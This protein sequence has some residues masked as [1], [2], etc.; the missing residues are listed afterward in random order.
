MGNY[1]SE[2]RKC[3][4]FYMECDICKKKYCTDCYINKLRNLK[5][6]WGCHYCGSS[7]GVHS[8]ERS[9]ISLIG[10]VKY[11]RKW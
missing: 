1:C 4:L 2:C 8:S 5:G 3:I 6:I 10:D 7:V 11:N 9:I